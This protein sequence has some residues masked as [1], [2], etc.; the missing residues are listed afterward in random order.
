[1]S[2]SGTG[3]SFKSIASTIL[4]NEV[5]G[6]GSDAT[7]AGEYGVSEL[8]WCPDTRRVPGVQPA[9]QGS[10]L[11]EPVTATARKQ[12]QCL[13]Q[14][15]TGN[16]DRGGIDRLADAITSAIALRSDLDI[17]IARLSTRGSGSLLF[18]PFVLSGALARLCVASWF[19]GVSVVHINVASKGSVYR[20]ALLA[21]VAR[22]LGIPYVVHL[23]NGAFDRFWQSAGPRLDRDHC[24]LVAKQRRNHCT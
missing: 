12:V 4:N 2:L 14:R 16:T 3:Q 20:K 5:P 15:P 17:R 23:H 19:G 9:L 18:S 21:A 8:D 10:H 6:N 24:R 22:K 7:P 1:M 13:L 11:S